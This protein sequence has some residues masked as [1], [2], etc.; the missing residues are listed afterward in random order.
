MEVS[1]VCGVEEV[2]KAQAELARKIPFVPRVAVVLGSGLGSFAD[3]IEEPVVVPYEEIPFWP[4]STA[5]GHAGRIVAGRLKGVPLVAMQGRVHLYEG[6]SPQEVVFPVRVCAAMGVKIYLATNASG[7]INQSYRP[8]DLVL[9]E[10][11][12][13]FMGVNPLTGPN[14][15]S[16]GVR[17]PDMTEAYSERLIKRAD[18]VASDGGIWVK[19][20]VYVAFHGPSFET[21]AEI[22]MARAMGGDLAG[23]STVPEVIAAN[24]LGLEVMALSCVAN[25]A[26]GMTKNRLTHEEVL[27]EMERAS[28]KLTRLL[29]DLLATLKDDV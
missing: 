12:I 23:M 7:G 11:H 28:G 18:K 6:Y 10:D 24:H 2:K 16:W 15:E 26:A 27:S 1:A 21:P 29:S 14:E 4:R 13:N 5:P 9:I 3:A 25:F 22:R 19:R 17:F 20:G 8:G